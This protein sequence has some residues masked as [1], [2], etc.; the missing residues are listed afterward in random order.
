MYTVSFTITSALPADL[1]YI[2]I[3]AEIDFASLLPNGGSDARLKPASIV[4]IDLADDTVVPHHLT[5]DFAHGDHGRVEFVIGDP[6]HTRY[7]IRFSSLAS[8]ETRP[9]LAPSWTVPVV[10]VGDLL[11]FNANEPRPIT[12]FCFRLVDLNGNGHADLA[13]TWN[14]YHRPG[15]ARSGVVC[16]PRLDGGSDALHCG[17]QVR[18]RFREPGSA[19]LF[20]FPGT[21][22][23][24]DFGN[25]SGNGEPD[26]VFTEWNTGR[27]EFFRS[28]GDTDD[29]GWPIWERDHQISVPEERVQSLSRVDVDGDGVL[30][31]LFN[32]R[33]IRNTNPA[34]WPFQ[35]ATPVDLGAGERIACLD[36]SADGRLDLLSVVERESSV[37]EHPDSDAAW[38]GA[39]VFWHARLP[40]ESVA[41][42]PPQPVV[43]LPPS[44]HR[45]A[46][47]RDL[48]GD[49]VLVQHNIWQEITFFEIH[50][51]EDG[52][53]IA[54]R[55][56]RAEADN[57]PMAF[58][59]QGWPCACDWNGNGV[60]DLLIGGGYGWP[61]IVRNESTDIQPA[62]REPELLV[63][64]STESE[65]KPIRL[66]RDEI[67]PPTKHWHNMGYP[68]P[69]FVDW[70]GDGLP[71][72]MLPNETN[73]I[74][75]YRN[76]GS[77][78]QPSFGPRQQ[79]IVEGYEDDADKRALV[80]QRA[81]DKDLPNHPYPFDD[82]S[83]SSGAPAPVSRTLPAMAPWTWSP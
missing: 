45:I 35:A 34:G 56:A 77:L 18:L 16:Y 80:G 22:V 41:F 32:G 5:E 58:S 40:G 57:P 33:W 46:A 26:L 30:D 81:L 75:W 50:L 29:G 68:Y 73:R 38:P 9:P 52:V 62:F 11:R 23:D 42:G 59:D 61:R 27:I 15:E 64:T 63:A 4:V 3:S 13:G 31:V 49:G 10:G 8:G 39:D 43:G 37:T 82:T 21:Y 55:L 83:P 53:A 14:Y 70:D 74:F 69:C 79:L 7:D 78:Q 24:A 28:T 1:G 2:P 72:L 54:T 71:D 44:A 47:A 17:D 36:I 65:A 6:T 48:D 51:G 19:Q 66:L 25:L 20:D 60:V 67:L 76:V 12:M